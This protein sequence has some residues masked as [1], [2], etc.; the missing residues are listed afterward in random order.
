MDEKRAISILFKN[1][2]DNKNMEFDIFFYVNKK[3][4][5]A[6]II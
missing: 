5:I 2:K 6:V 1:T 4:F 3:S